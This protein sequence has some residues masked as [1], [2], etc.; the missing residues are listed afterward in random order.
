MALPLARGL[1]PGEGEVGE[2]GGMRWEKWTLA[3]V[4]VCIVSEC[5]CVGGGRCLLE[6]NWTLSSVAVRF[7]CVCVFFFFF[8]LFFFLL[9]FLGGSV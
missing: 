6:E 9:F 4:T 8:V 2:G 7:V 3:R 1:P 5:V